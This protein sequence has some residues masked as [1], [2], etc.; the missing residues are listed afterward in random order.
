MTNAVWED[1]VDR[2]INGDIYETI[3]ELVCFPDKLSFCDFEVTCRAK[4]RRN[5][6]E[7]LS[8]KCF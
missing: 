7:K 8:K 3:D 6:S 1:D 2:T 5:E 4:V